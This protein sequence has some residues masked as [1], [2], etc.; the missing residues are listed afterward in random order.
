[1]LSEHE[2]S[3]AHQDSSSYEVHFRGMININ[4]NAE[5]EFNPLDEARVPTEM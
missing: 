1:M 5:L 4:R 2:G 3:V